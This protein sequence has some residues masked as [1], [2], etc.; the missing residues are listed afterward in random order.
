MNRIPSRTLSICRGIGLFSV[1]M[2]LVFLAP[3]CLPE[4]NN[5]RNAGPAS[6]SDEEPND[7]MP[8]DR[9]D[10]E[11]DEDVAACFE[12]C[13]EATGDEAACRER[14]A[15]AGSGEQQNHEDDDERQ[16]G[17]HEEQKQV[18]P[19]GIRRNCPMSS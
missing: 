10:G 18:E 15:E 8:D 5:Q 6:N 19:A 1:L 13:L 4:D 16:E 12:H 11:G 2:A 14:C 17:D 9:G 7:G 3:A